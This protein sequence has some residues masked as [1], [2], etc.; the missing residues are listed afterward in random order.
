MAG[1]EKPTVSGG[2][3]IDL[4]KDIKIKGIDFSRVC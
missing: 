4:G 3:V 2:M 1:E